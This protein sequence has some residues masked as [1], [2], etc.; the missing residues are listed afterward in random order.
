[1]KI[2]EQNISRGKKGLRITLHPRAN[3][4]VK[5]HEYDALGWAR[6][7]YAEILQ[8]LPRTKPS[9]ETQK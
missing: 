6:R 4:R 5:P 2:T 1:M 9:D 8:Q 3:I 7:S